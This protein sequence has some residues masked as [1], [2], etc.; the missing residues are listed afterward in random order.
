[1]AKTR[2]DGLILDGPDGRCILVRGTSLSEAL[3]RARQ[4]AAEDGYVLTAPGDVR[5]QW[6]RA[7]PCPP[8]EHSHDGWTCDRGPGVFYLPGMP[9][10]GAFQGI[11][12]DLAYQASPTERTGRQRPA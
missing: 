3:D 5:L 7:V 11:L 10:R 8:R 12:A 2:R 1:M 9:G 4:W 6:I